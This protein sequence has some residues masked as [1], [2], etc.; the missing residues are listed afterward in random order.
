MHLV[1][2]SD[3]SLF[4]NSLVAL[5]IDTTA[6]PNQIDLDSTQWGYSSETMDEEIKLLLV[7]DRERNRPLYFRYIPG[8]IVDVSTLETTNTEMEKLGIR[9]SLTIM[10][11]GFFSEDN[12]RSMFKGKMDFLIRVPANR[13]IYHECIESSS[14]I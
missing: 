12:I 7:M 2:R 5:S 4:S 9:S 3:I 1:L 13:S 8:S 14:D 11:A 6:L 10:D